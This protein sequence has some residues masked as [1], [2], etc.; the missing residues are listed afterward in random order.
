[1]QTLDTLT[2]IREPATPAPGMASWLPTDAWVRLLLVP[3]LAFIAL[4]SSTAYLADFWHHLA[5]GRVIVA[6]GRLL[7]HDI[8]TFTAAGQTFRDVNWLAQVAYFLLF[9][10]GGLALVQLVNSLIM[11]LALGLFICLCRRLS[12]SSVAAAIVGIATFLGMWQVLTIRPQTFSL[13][14]FVVVFDLLERSERRP[15]LLFFLPVLLALW[16]NLHGA[17]PAGLMLVGCY[18]VAALA[19][20]WKRGPLWRDRR[21]RQLAACLGAC[22]LATLVNPYGWHVYLYVGLTSNVAASRG[23][24]E[25]VRPGFGQAIGIAFFLSLLFL[26]VLVVVNWKRHG[27]R[28]ELRDVVLAVC[29]LPLAAGSVRMVAWWLLVTGPIA[30]VLV[31]QLLP[32]PKAPENKPTVGAG[33]TCAVLLL[34]AVFSVPGLSA[35]NPLLAFRPKE[36]VEQNLDAVLERLGAAPRA[37]RVFTRFEWGEYFAWAGN[38]RFTIFMDGRIEI[39]SDKVWKEYEAITVGR[40]WQKILDDYHVDTLALDSDYHARTGLLAKVE[41]SPDWVQVFRAGTALLYGRRNG[42]KALKT[43]STVTENPG[44]NRDVAAVPKAKTPCSR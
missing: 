29:F 25:W 11:S 37:A 12:G 19:I 41:T 7:D 8:F 20:A 6:E 5:R 22:V 21:S 27:Y 9:N 14:L 2:Q 17:F 36:R 13:F 26:L 30:T 10:E 32:V 43:F 4:A 15:A 23:I 31:A 28:P 39:F 35:Y 1:M 3:V 34:L 16:A 33:L 38:Q 40:D 44:N 18:L 24:D 42:A